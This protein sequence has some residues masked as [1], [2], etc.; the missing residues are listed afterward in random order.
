MH[1]N[2]PSP[3]Q[4]TGAGG[5]VGLYSAENYV[6][7]QPRFISN[8][9]VHI[10]GAFSPFERQDVQGLRVYGLVSHS[11]GFESQLF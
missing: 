7:R 8:H 3:G 6:Q 10:F 11:P 4:G 9:P 2:W 5:A 1:L